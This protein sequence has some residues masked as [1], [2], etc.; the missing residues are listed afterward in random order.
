MHK[1][2]ICTRTFPNKIALLY[3]PT[4]IVVVDIQ[5]KKPN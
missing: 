3:E 4:N 1:F 5:I 2:P